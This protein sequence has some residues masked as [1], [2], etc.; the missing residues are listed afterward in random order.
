MLPDL[1]HNISSVD[2]V[3]SIERIEQEHDL[4]MF[5]RTQYL[6]N[7]MLPPDELSETATIPS[8][9]RKSNAIQ[10]TLLRILSKIHP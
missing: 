8:F 7:G 3:D 1:L 6:S 9:P 5:D 2:P 10:T 4:R